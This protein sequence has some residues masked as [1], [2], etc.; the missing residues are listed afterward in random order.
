MQVAVATT[1]SPTLGSTNSSRP[2]P[3]GAADS[4]PNDYD[5]AIWVVVGAV[6]V[7][8]LVGGGT[9]YLTR[10]RRIDLSQRTTPTEDHHPATERRHHQK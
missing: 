5:G 7:V 3:P 9:F 6:I 1:P 2:Q 4:S 8:A 10:T